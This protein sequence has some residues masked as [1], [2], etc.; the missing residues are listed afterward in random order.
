MRGGEDWKG[1]RKKK[2]VLKKKE[3]MEKKKQK[4]TKK[5]ELTFQEYK[6]MLHA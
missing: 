5:K 2:K 6:E 1:L 4:K 3:K